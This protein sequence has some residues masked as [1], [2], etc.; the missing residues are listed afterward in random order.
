MKQIFV[1]AEVFEGVIQPVTM[2]LIAAALK[3]V[4]LQKSGII[5][6]IVP[7]DDPL[8]IAR[9]IAKQTDFD[10][11]A[12]QTIG[13]KGCNYDVYKQ[14]LSWL[15]KKM[16]PS[17][18]LIAHTSCSQNFV[19][20]LAIQI[21]AAS[22]PGVNNIKLDDK[23]LIFSRPV[24]NNTKNMIVRP[25]PGMPVIL[26][27]MQGAFQFDMPDKIVT[28]KKDTCKFLFDLKPNLEP[29]LKPDGKKRIK[30]K[31]T[32]KKNCDNHA[33]KEAKTVV[34]AGQ[35]I[36]KKENLDTI[37]QFAKCFSSSAV[38]ASRPLIDMGWIGYEHQ[39]GITGTT[40]LPKLYIA[41]GISGSSQHLAGMKDAQFVVSINNNP[42]AP[43]FNHS[44]LSI[45]E[46][47]FEFIQ[48]FL[49]EVDKVKTKPRQR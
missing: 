17:H 27:I 1:I 39:V 24:L 32:I 47:V 7:L 18:T 5:K 42:A 44:D 21:K 48:V 22:I 26:T 11:T 29:N 31:K 41:C 10:V 40:V 15:I 23:G 3:I 9:Q 8:P 14:Y 2:E 20:G 45:V 36:G 34:S 43:I 16:E 12:L 6:I 49:K 19:P 37:F 25:K 4:E 38:G 33:L 13:F 28:G 35:G 30:Y 46:D